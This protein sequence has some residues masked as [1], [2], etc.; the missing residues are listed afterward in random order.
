MVKSR[1]FVFF[2]FVLIGLAG[3][4]IPISE[5]QGQVSTGGEALIIDLEGPINPGTATYVTR[6]LEEARKM[7]AVLA[8]IR[9]DT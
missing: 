9:L 3:Y 6:G 7:G 8:V 1:A 2:C 5:S 4:G